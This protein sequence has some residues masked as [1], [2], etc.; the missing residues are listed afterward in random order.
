MRRTLKYTL[1]FCLVLNSIA[2][3]TAQEESYFIER[4]DILSIEV[5][6]HPEFSRANILVLPDGFI[7][8]PALGSMKASGLTA[9]Q[10]SDSIR[11][12]LTGT[13][14]VTPIVSVHLH[15]LQNQSVNVLGAVNSPGRV[16]IFEPIGLTTALARAGGI[17]DFKRA[18]KIIVIKKDASVTEI[19][20]RKMI[21]RNEFM[22]ENLP[23]IETEDTIIVLESS[24]EWGKWSFY[25]TLTYALLR[26]ID[27]FL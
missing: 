12:A 10:L 24:V 9:R 17:K 11:V 1:A 18:K 16:Q 6:E 25:A 21:R 27:L 15:R 26:V 7:Q 19:K 8:Y 2:L 23:V 3:L 20:Y 14:I 13:Y 22:D 4:G 5:M